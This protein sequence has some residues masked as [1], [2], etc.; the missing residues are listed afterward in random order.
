M[1]ALNLV[2][3]YNVRIQ[4]QVIWSNFNT[5]YDEILKIMKNKTN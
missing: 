4:Q 1:K 3:T 5:V 2:H